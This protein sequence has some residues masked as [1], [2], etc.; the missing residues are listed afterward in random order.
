MRYERKYK[1]ETLSL[2]LI[3]QILRR[4]PAS[5]RKTYPDRQINNIYFDTPNYTAYTENVM[6]IAQRKKY[7]IRWYGDREQTWDKNILEI[8]IKDNELGRKESQPFPAFDLQDISQLG[9][10][11]SPL[12]SSPS[13]L[14]PVLLNA[15][16]RF[17]Y[18]S[19]NG[20]F[21][22]TIDHRMRYL[23]LA[24]AKIPGPF[25]WEDPAIVLELKYE[26]GL[27]DAAQQIRQYLPFRQT[28]SSKYVTG[29]SL[30]IGV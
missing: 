19:F 10:Q 22:I 17:Y 26:E 24:M 11:V 1:L 3:Q 15:Y 18:A 2:D 21:R 20:K 14:K 8:K 9:K 16:H 30:L 7:R 13:T 29:I 4:H 27:E 28:K 23:P 6:G 25:I 12:L 5:F